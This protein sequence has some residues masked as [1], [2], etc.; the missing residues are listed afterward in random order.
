MLTLQ[1]RHSPKCPD[2]NKGPNY[3][4]CRGQ[5]PLRV[6]GTADGPG[7]VRLSLKTRDLQRAARK[8]TEMEDRLSGKPRKPLRDA[9]QAFQA[10][11]EQNAEETKRRY[12][13]LLQYFSDFCSTSSLIYVDQINVESLDRYALERGKL[14][15]W[16]KDVELLRQFFEFCRDREWTAKNPARALRIPKAQEP[17]DVVPYKARRDCENHLRV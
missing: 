5:C 2:R 9:L 15:S 6:G 1:R 17:R 3:L 4:K 16:I 8:L 7:R 10:Q 11:Y 12:R 14:M 13:R